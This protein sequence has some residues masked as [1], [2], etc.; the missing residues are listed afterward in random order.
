MKVDIGHQLRLHRGGPVEVGNVYSNCKNRYFRVVI[1]IVKRQC[2]RP[3][4]N[5]VCMHVDATGEIVGSSNQPELYV[6]E[7]QDLVGKVLDMPSMKITWFED[8]N[9][10]HS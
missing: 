2:N 5:V 8:E 7:H 3:W 9:Y 4:N 6:S 10:P 1:G